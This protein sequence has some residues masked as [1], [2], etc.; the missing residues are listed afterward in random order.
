MKVY[1]GYKGNDLCVTCS[2]STDVY[3]FGIFGTL[4]GKLMLS[5]VH[6]WEEA[7]YIS[8]IDRDRFSS[9]ILYNGY[10]CIYYAHALDVVC[11]FRDLKNRVGPLNRVVWND[12]KGSFTQ[13]LLIFR[14]GSISN[15]NMISIL[16]RDTK[17]SK[18]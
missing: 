6:N 8:I 3:S 13:Y 17:W 9:E 11:L 5:N 10:K 1:Y 15:K 4:K 2:D 12:S 14:K 18:L 16:G 7:D